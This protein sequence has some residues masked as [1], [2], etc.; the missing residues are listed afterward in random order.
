MDI[1]ED[2]D[3]DLTSRQKE[4][5]ELLVKLEKQ[6]KKTLQNHCWGAKAYKAFIHHIT[7][8]RRNILAARPFF[9]ERQGE[10]SK[11]ISPAI[12]KNKHKQLYRFNIN[13]PFIEFIL[14]SFNWPKNG[15]VVAAAQRVFEIRQKII[16]LNMPLAITQ[17]RIF[18]HVTPDSHLSYMDINQISF[19]GLINAVDKFCLPY[20][21]VFRSVIIGRS[22][23]D[24]IESSSETLLHFYPSDKR[25]I[26][27][28]N[29]AQKGQVREEVNF[30]KLSENVNCS[31][32]KLPSP[33]TPAEIQQLVAASGTL[34]MDSVVTAGGRCR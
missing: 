20:S 33:T 12:R 28:A 22:K 3:R 18:R 1:G 10:F 8:D 2:L 31:G 6:F 26:Y 15:K 14:R 21:P 7:Q 23:G 17:A 13:Y 9:R 30:T 27:R 34:S 11:G 32:P 4:Q 19:E 25:K 5:V 29:K 16:I 24:L